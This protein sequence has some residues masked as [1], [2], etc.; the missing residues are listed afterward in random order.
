MNLPTPLPSSSAML[1]RRGMARFGRSEWQEL[2]VLAASVDV[3]SP[4]AFTLIELL[5][6]IG[7][8]AMLAALLLPVLG[9][10]KTKGQQVYCVNNFHQLTLS[11]KM[12][13]DENGGKLVP[14][15][16]FAHGAVNTNA[17]V[18][19]SM[20]DDTKIYPPVEPGVKDSTNFNGIKLGS[21][22]TLNRSV[23]V[24]HCPAD[25]STVDGVRRVRSYSLNGWMGGTWVAGQSNYVV[26]KREA[27]IVTPS[28]AKAWVFIDEH[29]RS[30]NDGWFAVDMRG[31]RGLLDAPATRHNNAYGLSFADGHGEV[32]KLRDSRSINWKV[33][34][35]SNH[36][37]NPDWQRLMEAS[38]CLRQ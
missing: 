33:L 29:E 27:D 9:K 5:V 36:P 7:I 26:F 25:M 13:A 10:S 23:G 38:S 11:W 12:Y 3:A 4:C 28:P 34:P 2:K 15:F 14:I 30:I 22:Y 37:L 6:V 21:L 17:W 20:N 8:I 19:G 16:Y 35:I 32:W 1:A 24:Y 18:R 31:E